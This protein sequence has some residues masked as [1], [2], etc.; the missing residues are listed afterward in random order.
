MLVKT[1]HEIFAELT[2]EEL[3]AVEKITGS[4]SNRRYERWRGDSASLIY[5]QGESVEENDTFLYLSEHFRTKGLPVPDVRWVSPDR[6]AYFQQDLGEVSLFDF[7]KKGRTS[8]NF[9]AEEVSMLEKTIRLLPKMQFVGAQG[10]DFSKCYQQAEFD[11]HTVMWDLNYFKYCFLKPSG[12][13]FSEEKLERD[14]EA[15]SHDLLQD[16]TDTFLYRDF[17]SRNVMLSFGNPCFIDYQGG[18]KG[19]VYYD[20]ASF[21]WQAKANLPDSLRSRLV[22]AYYE[23]LQSYMKI[24]RSYFDD[25]L[26]KFLLFRLLQVLGAYGYR[27]F[28]ERKSHFLESIPPAVKN[29]A[30]LLKQNFTEYAYMREV[31]LEMCASDKFKEQL[32]LDASKLIVEVNSFSYKKGIPQDDSGNGGGYVFDCRWVHNPG[33]YEE[34]KQLTGLDKPVIDF[35]ENDGEIFRFLEPIY[36]LA[37]DHVRRYMERGFTHLMFSFGCTG[38]Q[39]RSVYSAQHVAEFIHRKFG[40]EVHLCHREQGIKQEFKAKSEK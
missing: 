9:S 7:I 30:N 37:S 29:L 21:V 8:G 38:G 5:V 28:F 22:D 18:R 6:T 33:R 16:R 17:Q 2:G 19:P 35:L 23:E 13:Y 14:F 25:K 1:L 27:G 20:V 10:L 12:V 4:G 31:L 15:L 11:V 40:V 39:H 24:N 32:P 34:Y 36:T 3:L 26:K